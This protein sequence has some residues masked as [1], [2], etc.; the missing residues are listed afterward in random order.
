MIWV[1]QKHVNYGG[2]ATST[3]WFGGV[4]ELILTVS[5]GVWA[6]HQ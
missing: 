5:Q 3:I 1:F 4:K 2:D 6:R